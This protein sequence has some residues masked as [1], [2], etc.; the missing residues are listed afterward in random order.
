[1]TIDNHTA[2]FVQNLV[3]RFPGMYFR[4]ISRLTGIPIGTLDHAIRNL[5]KKGYIVEEKIWR[6]KKYF[7]PDLERSDRKIIGLLRNPTVRKIVYLTSKGVGKKDMCRHLGVTRPTL[8]W[9]IKKME[10]D[11]ILHRREGKYVPSKKSV[12]LLAMYRSSFS[13]KMVE[14]FISMWE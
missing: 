2:S 13:I 3:S 7:S 4:E 9:Y 6:N 10:V 8:N 1:M 12:E 14:N 5:K 11:G